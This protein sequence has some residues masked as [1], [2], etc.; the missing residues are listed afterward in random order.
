MRE[1]VGQLLQ[2]FQ[3]SAVDGKVPWAEYQAAISQLGLDETAQQ[4]FSTA[5]GQL[6]LQVSPVPCPAPVLLPHARSVAKATDTLQPSRAARV[7]GLVR[8]CAADDRVTEEQLRRLAAL[9]GL[10]E[11]EAKELPAVVR[12]AGIAVMSADGRRPASAGQDADSI[13]PG[14]DSSEAPAQPWTEPDLDAAITAAHRLLDE[15]TRSLRPQKRLLRAEEEV[16]LSILLRGGVDQM[17]IEPEDELF[18]QLPPHHIRRRARDAFVL[19]N[20]GLVHDMVKNYLGQGLEQEDLEQHG[21]AK[22][23]HAACKFDAR[24]GFKFSTYATHWVRQTLQRAIA[25]EGAAIRIPV[26]LHET[27][28]KVAAAESRFRA[29]GRATT[30]AAIA[31]ACGLEVTAVDKVRKISR[32]TDSLD[33]VIGDGTHLGELLGISRPAPGPEDVLRHKMSRECV[34]QVLAR[35]TEREADIVRRR[36]GLIDGEVQTL[37]DIGNVYGVTRERIRQLEVRAYKRLR[38]ELAPPPPSEPP[39][40]PAP[41]TEDERVGEDASPPVPGDE[42]HEDTVPM[43][44]TPEPYV[45]PALFVV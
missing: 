31:I 15:D 2:R 37:E 39:A 28:R 43:P 41:A 26:H 7:M 11:G 22:L 10:T 25:D 21:F 18:A 13:A 30:A 6:G 29:E 17:N 20:Q 32:V 5:L 8:R 40:T 38:E 19:H 16:G 1:T 24:K 35:R 14:P 44:I 3:S 42:R 27:V 4:R 12:R 36:L 23:M 45:Q 33:R 9:C 34:D